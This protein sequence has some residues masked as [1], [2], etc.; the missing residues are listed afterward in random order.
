MYTVLLFFYSKTS[1]NNLTLPCEKRHSDEKTK[2][3]HRL[4]GAVKC[5]ELSPYLNIFT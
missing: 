4:E 3:W 5:N 1:E 2:R